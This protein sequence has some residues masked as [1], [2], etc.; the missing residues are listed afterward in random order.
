MCT[1]PGTA[2]VLRFLKGDISSPLTFVYVPT[3]MIGDEDFGLIAPAEAHIGIDGDGNQMHVRCDLGADLGA[4]HGTR[5]R[6]FPM[7]LRANSRNLESVARSPIPTLESGGR[8]TLTL[9]FP[10]HLLGCKLSVRFGRGIVRR[11][12]ASCRLASDDSAGLSNRG[13]GRAP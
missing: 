4:D 11:H 6:R 5:P 12:E 8:E 13:H 7:H 2:T 3:T 9:H 1:G 10:D